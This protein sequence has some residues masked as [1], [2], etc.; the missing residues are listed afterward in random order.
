MDRLI[1][2]AVITHRTRILLRKTVLQIH[3]P[4]CTPDLI[5]D[6]GHANRTQAES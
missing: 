4:A 5:E 1:E 6:E 2:V 3:R